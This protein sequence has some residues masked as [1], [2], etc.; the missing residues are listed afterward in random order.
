MLFVGA[1]IGRNAFD[2]TGAEAPDG[3]QLAKELVSRFSIDLQ[4]EDPDLSKIAQLVELRKGRP[5]LDAFLAKRLADLEPDENVLWLFSRQWKAIFTTNYD[6]VIERAYA[7]QKNPVQT[8]VPIGSTAD[9]VDFN[10]LFEVPVYHL[11]GGLFFGARPFALIT[12]TDYATFREHRRMLFEI[13]KTSYAT[14]PILYVGY[15]HRDP[16]WLQVTTELSEEYQPSKPPTS[17]RVAPSTPEIDVEIM[18]SRGVETIHAD[19]AEFRESVIASLGDITV[20]PGRLTELE[21]TIPADLRDAFATSPAAV[22]RLLN[23]WIYLNQERFTDAPPNIGEFLAG[24]HANWPLIAQGKPFERDLEEEVFDDLLDFATSTAP[25]TSTHILLG[26]AGYGVS[27]LLMVLA[28]RL[29][30]DRAGAVFVHRRGSALAEGDIEFASGLFD[31]PVFLFVDNGADHATSLSD[32]VGRLRDAKATAALVVGERLNEWRQLPSRL[33]GQ[34]HGLDLLSEGEISRLL[35]YLDANS[36]LGRLADLSQELRVTAIRERHK[37]EL[38]VA[39]KEATE[40]IGFA[41]IIE[42]EYRGVASEFSRK[43]YAVVCSFYRLR[44]MVRDQVIAKIMGVP[45]TEVYERSRDETEGVIVWEPIDEANGVYAARARHRVIAEIVWQRGPTASEREDL[46]LSAMDALNLNYGS[47]ARAFEQ[48]VRS[49]DAV[50]GIGSFEGKVQFFESAVR[51]DPRSPY[52]HQHFARMLRRESRYDLALAEI[53]RGLGIDPDARVLH[54]TKGLILTDLA[55]STDSDEVRRRWLAKGEECLRGTV[56]LAPRDE[57]VYQALAL[58]YLGWARRVDDDTE[59]AE[60]AARAEEV[61]SS[62]LRR[63]RNLERLWV[64]SAEVAR[65]LG[66]NPASLEALER[67]ALATETGT[68][69]RYLLARRYRQLGRFEDAADV[70]RVVVENSPDEF[71]ACVEYALALRSL[72]RGYREC[73]AV[74]RLGDLYGDRDPRYIAVLGGMLFMSGEFSEA[75][76]LFSRARTQGFSYQEET[77]VAFVPEADGETVRLNGEVKVV[78]PGYAFIQ[79]AGYPD[80]F[81]PGSKFGSLRMRPGL[82]ISFTPAFTAKGQIALDVELA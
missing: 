32:A 56:S 40:G 6:S 50:D 12:E 21:E 51:K 71:R 26:P 60:Y 43:L 77:R 82:A 18:A 41:S 42:D 38:L 19:L 54:H 33:S 61:I 24:D 22:A 55:L 34:E 30:R 73:I 45:L 57:Y 35:D 59:S 44:V 25:G 39:M 1:G 78:K 76:Q 31:G 4:G 47:D 48:L 58:L 11:H 74:L 53:D 5:E 46:L 10:P 69:G 16:N 66:D 62:G 81:C 28:A 17:Y 13:L 49:D 7:R 68:I 70:V 52:V 79:A 23:S 15:S 20:D 72:G 64:V 80:F 29:V 36:A 27:T 75:Q 14:N 8:P 2:S 67:A 63:A 65:F 9:L 37:Q 3:R